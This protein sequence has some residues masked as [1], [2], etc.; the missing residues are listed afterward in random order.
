MNLPIRPW[1]FALLLPVVSASLLANPATTEPIVA[2][3][4]KQAGIFAERGLIS[5]GSSRDMV[6]SLLGDP[7]MRVSDEFWI[8]WDFRL[9]P[10]Q[11]NPRGFDA[12]IVR[13]SADIV[14]GMKLSD[15][16]LIRR[17]L[18]RKIARLHR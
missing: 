10:E 9:R 4:A 5:I 17:A 1:L 7:E 15:G 6:A 8:Y 11:V 14:A 12:L 13:F 3:P 16:E 18:V 2:Y